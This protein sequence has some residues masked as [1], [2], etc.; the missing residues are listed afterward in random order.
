VLLELLD[1]LVTPVIL[2]ILVIPGLLAIQVPLVT[3][4]PPGVMDEQDLL[5]IL[6]LKAQLDLKV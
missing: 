5:V 2:V 6:D 1:I 4:V 3:Q